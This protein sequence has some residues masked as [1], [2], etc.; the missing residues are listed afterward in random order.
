MQ[1]G[2]DNCLWGGGGIVW[3]LG[4]MGGRAQALLPVVL[5]TESSKTALLVLFVF[6]LLLLEAQDSGV[7]LT[8][9]FA[10][11]HAVGLHCPAWCLVSIRTFLGQGTPGM[12]LRKVVVPTCIQARNSL[13]F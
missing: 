8:H 1:V 7:N 12:T 2:A 13:S 5:G 4:W 9:R 10:V 3:A 6:P 11:G